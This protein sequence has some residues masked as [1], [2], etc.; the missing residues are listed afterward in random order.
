MTAAVHTLYA[1]GLKFMLLILCMALP[2]ALPVLALHRD[3]DRIPNI[4][5]PRI[6]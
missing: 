6:P 5:G 3:I 2:L 1:A 4:P